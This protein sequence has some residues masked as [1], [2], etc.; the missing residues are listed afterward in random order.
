M[1]VLFKEGRKE[2]FIE[3]FNKNEKMQY[4]EK[5]QK[6]WSR[7]LIIGWGVKHIFSSVSSVIF[8]SRR[9]LLVF[10]FFMYEKVLYL[11]LQARRSS[12]LISSFFYKTN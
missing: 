7:N 5:N 10:C 9:R 1:G 6:F 8:F 12:F 11:F 4:D 3:T 2:L